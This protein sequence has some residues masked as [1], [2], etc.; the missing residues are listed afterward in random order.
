MRNSFIPD[1]DFEVRIAKG[2]RSLQEPLSV[3]IVQPKGI[4]EKPRN[5]CIPTTSCDHPI[6][7]RTTEYRRGRRGRKGERGRRGRKGERGH[8]RSRVPES[9]WPLSVLSVTL[10]QGNHPEGPCGGKG[11]PS[12]E[13]LKGNM[14]GYP[15]T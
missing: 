6:I 3:I 4:I 10:N 14:A 7:E 9:G 13:P 11:A 2:L 8:P 1:L 5:S 12:R 15:E